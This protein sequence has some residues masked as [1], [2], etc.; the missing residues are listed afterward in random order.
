MQET[1]ASSSRMDVKL[2]CMAQCM[3]RETC[4][5]NTDETAKFRTLGTNGVCSLFVPIPLIPMCLKYKK[6]RRCSCTSDDLHLNC[7][8]SLSCSQ[9]MPIGT[10]PS[11]TDRVYDSRLPYSEDDSAELIAWIRMAKAG[12]LIRNE[13]IGQ[14][15]KEYPNMHFDFNALFIGEPNG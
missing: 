15:T 12:E 5:D 3:N 8:G 7:Q 13:V 6:H 9:Y 11:K 2:T 10:Q 1:T 14:V 4:T